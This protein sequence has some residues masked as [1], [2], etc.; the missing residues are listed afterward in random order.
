MGNV[1]YPK[2]SGAAMADFVSRRSGEAVIDS[3]EADGRSIRVRLGLQQK[4]S[5]HS[6]FQQRGCAVDGV[7]R[8][9]A[10]GSS[11][12]WWWRINSGIGWKS[13]G[14]TREDHVVIC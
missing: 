2:R 12:L 1:F 10:G 6:D 14:E 3:L 13:R 4:G 9:A 8:A 11:A 7:R 5:V